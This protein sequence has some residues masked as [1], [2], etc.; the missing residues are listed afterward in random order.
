[1]LVLSRKEGEQIVIGRDIVVSVQRLS[2][3]RVRLGIIA[4]P[5]TRV[6]R[7]EIDGV[8]TDWQRGA[9]ERQVGRG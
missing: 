6:V 4:P 3:N 9:A 5:E 1:M 2:G 7:A 8:T